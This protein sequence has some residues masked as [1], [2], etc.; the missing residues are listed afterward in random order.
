MIRIATDT[1]ANLPQD[2]IDEFKIVVV[3]GTIDFGTETVIEYPDLKNEEFYRR[4][5][6]SRTLPVA[7]D[8]T[9]IQFKREYSRMFS[10]TPSATILSVHVSEALGTAITAAR[11]AASMLPMSNIKLFDTRSVSF[12]QGLLVWEAAR[13]AASGASV[14]QIIRRLATLRD[15]TKLYI[16]VDTLEY[17]SRGGR[18]GPAAR[19]VGGLLSVK[20]VLTLKD[21]LV[22]GHSQHRTRI[23]AL[24]ELKKLVLKEAKGVEG[25]RMGVIHAVCTD[26][27]KQLAEDIR[28]ALHPEALAIAE[29]GPAV[30]VHAGPGALGVTWFSNPPPST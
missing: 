10:E 23:K 27:A 21:G 12:G 4:L 26:E 8:P 30:G 3:S 11:Q 6:S 2:I 20:P 14:D 18:V 28:N 29:I 19:L 24:D 7:H 25:L 17:L 5:T 22:Q 16:V 9:V 1:G 15:H 13:M